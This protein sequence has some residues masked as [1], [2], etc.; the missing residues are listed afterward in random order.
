[1]NTAEAAK[2][3]L[4]SWLTHH[5]FGMVSLRRRATLALLFAARTPSKALAA[6]I[7]DLPRIGLQAV[8][9][10][11]IKRA[12]LGLPELTGAEID[13]IHAEAERPERDEQERWEQEQRQRDED[14]ATEDAV[15]LAARMTREQLYEL[16]AGLDHG[17]R[18]ILRMALLLAAAP[19]PT[20]VIPIGRV[21]DAV[22]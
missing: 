12:R 11:A 15:R 9:R 21:R 2:V 5:V 1:M 8:A 10:E 22:L 7:H 18:T 3:P 4:P 17:R 20:N 13:A 19:T 16:V 6:R 14:R